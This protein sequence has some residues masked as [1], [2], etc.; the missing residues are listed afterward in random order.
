MPRFVLLS[1]CTF[2]LFV[3]QLAFAECEVVV[4]VNPSTGK[5]TSGTICNSGHNTV[6]WDPRKGPT[7]H[8]HL[9]VIISGGKS[10]SGLVCD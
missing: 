7:S 2:A 1:V 10:H 4:R 9:E 3:S 8:C 5:T 6:S